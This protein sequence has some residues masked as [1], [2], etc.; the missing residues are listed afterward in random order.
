MRRHPEMDGSQARRRIPDAA[1]QQLKLPFVP[2][3][4]S[5]GQPFKLFIR[6]GVLPEL[7]VV[8]SIQYSWPEP[9]RRHG[10]LVLRSAPFSQV[11]VSV[12]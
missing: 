6:H 7:A 10:A 1:A 8:G 9:T 5:T 4:S 11:R 12:F 2:L 3:S